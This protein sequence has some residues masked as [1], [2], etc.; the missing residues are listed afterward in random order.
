M[1]PATQFLGALKWGFSRDAVRK[2]MKEKRL[3]MEKYSKKKQ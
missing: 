3:R 2:A 1:Q